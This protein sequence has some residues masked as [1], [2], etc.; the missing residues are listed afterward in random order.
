MGVPQQHVSLPICLQPYHS[1]PLLSLVPPQLRLGC[2]RWAMM[3]ILKHPTPGF[4]EVVAAHFRTLRG[5]IMT[6]C[7]RWVREASDLDAVLQR[8]M[9]AAVQELYGLLV[10]L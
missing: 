7:Q 5:R 1:Q 2:I 9:D 6:T 8:R 10:K 3:D 4:E